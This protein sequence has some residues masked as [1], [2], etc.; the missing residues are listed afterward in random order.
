MK[1]VE[2][3]RVSQSLSGYGMLRGTVREF[4]GVEKIIKERLEAGWDFAGYVP[5]EY[6]GNGEMS[7]I[8]LVF[9]K[10]EEDA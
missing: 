6:R 9:T 1:K 5:V 7:E 2:F 3:T 10:E 8:S 4:P